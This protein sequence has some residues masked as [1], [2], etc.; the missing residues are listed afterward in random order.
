MKLFGRK[1]QVYPDF[2]SGSWLLGI[3]MSVSHH[4]M[5][6]QFCLGPFSL[7]FLGGPRC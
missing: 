3:Y 5:V 4:G 7:N 1:W 6:F 2:D